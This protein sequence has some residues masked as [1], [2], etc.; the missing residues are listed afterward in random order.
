LEKARQL[1]LEFLK[2]AQQQP[3]PGLMLA[4][5]L[6]LGS[7]LFHLGQLEASLDHMNSAIRNHSGSAE[8]VLALFAGPDIGV[9]CRSYLA[10]LA[11]HRESGKDADAHAEEAIAAA[12]RM[13]H[14]F[15]H[16]IALD[17][18]AMLSV[19]RAESRVALERGREAVELCSRYGFAYYLAMANILTGWA[20]A[21]EG[22]VAAGLTQLREG[23]EGCAA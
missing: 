13:R 14:P 6:L 19:F 11:W 4:G 2:V 15:S 17:Y 9:F 8:S 18:A 1:G 12:K 7:S 23:L 20:G 10:H 16:A 21:A 22:D 5:N 3:T